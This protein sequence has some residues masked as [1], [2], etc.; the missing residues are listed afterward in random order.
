MKNL[1]Y[2]FKCS[3]RKKPLINKILTSFILILLLPQ[4]SCNTTEPPPDNNNQYLEYEWTIDTLK[5][6][7]GYGVVPWSMWGS[8]PQNVWIAGFNLAGQGELFHWDGTLWTRATPDLGFNYDLSSVIGFAEN[9]IYIAGYK[10]II[11]TVQH[12]ESIILHYNG[13]IWQQEPIPIKGDA[14]LFISG[15]NS[16]NIWACGNNGSLYNKTGGIWKKISFDEREYL[17][18]LSVAP[19]LGPIY[20][21]PNGDVFLMNKYYNYQVY[22]DT[23][24][25]YFSKYSNGAWQDLDSCRLVNVDGIATGYKFGDRAIWG[26]SASEIYSVSNWAGLFKFNGANWILETWESR[27]EYKDVKGTLANK[28]FVVG[29]HGTIKYFDGSRWLRIPGF[30]NKIVDFYSVMPFED[31]IFIGAYQLGIGYAVRGK[32]KK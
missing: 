26:I 6:P 32:A 9:D 31:E 5:N 29:E 12:S 30:S 2:F 11:D 16:S 14:L 10:I 24:M 20:V 28:I 15:K 3:L 7:N 1:F 22:G 13:S 17:G 21:A 4:Y 18:E 25:F 23:A 27:Y 8:S 19:D